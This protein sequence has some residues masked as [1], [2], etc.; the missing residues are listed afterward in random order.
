MWAWGHFRSTEGAYGFDPSKSRSHTQQTPVKITTSR[1][2][3]DIAS[4]AN[5]AVL[6]LDDGDIY[7]FGNVSRGANV[8]TR[9]KRK[10]NLAVHVAVRKCAHLTLEFFD[11]LFTF[12]LAATAIWAGG[13]HVF[14][15]SADGRVWAYGRNYSGQLGLG[16]P[17]KDADG[18]K[19][20]NGTRG[21]LPYLKQPVEVTAVRG[22]NVVQIACG[23]DHTIFRTD[24]GEVY[25]WYA[26]N[27]FLL[28]YW[29]HFA[30][31]SAKDG[32]LGL[33][34][35]A[36]NARAVGV[37]TLVNIVENGV[38]QRVVYVAT[39]DHHSLFVAASG[40]AFVCGIGG[41]YRLGT[42]KDDDE[43]VPVQV[44]GQ[45]LQGRSV[46]LAEGGAFHSIF[47]AHKENDDG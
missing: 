22:K 16:I 19:L 30:S 37:P 41:E 44:G 5:V 8:K 14:F 9:D 32:R 28:L 3:V 40:A 17:E 46:V 27:K 2:V 11:S 47:A 20:E 38:P 35:S 15:K 13:Y 6:L 39:G 29:R 45:R 23:D 25:T 7:E 21:V 26:Q 34:E 31:G 18:A 42:G 33:G 12:R 24:D 43:L 1:P 4:D 36:V 10:H